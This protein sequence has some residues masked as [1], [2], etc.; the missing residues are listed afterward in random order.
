MAGGAYKVVQ[1]MPYGV[2][3]RIRLRGSTNKKDDQVRHIDEIR[4][5]RR[6]NS[7]YQ[8]ALPNLFWRL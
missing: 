4:L 8:V 6:F 3:Y 2:D 5:L 7:V 1:V